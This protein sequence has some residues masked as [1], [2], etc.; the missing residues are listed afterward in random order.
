MKTRMVRRTHLA[1][2]VAGLAVSVLAV[3]VVYAATNSYVSTEAEAATRSGGAATLAD[4]SASGG[5]AVQFGTG[6]GGACPT[7]KRTITATD[8]SQVKNSGYPAGTQVYIPGSPDPW[9]GCFPSAANTGIPAGTTLT[10]YTGPCTITTPNTTIT[11]R[12]INCSLSIRAANVVIEHSK[13]TGGNIAIDSAGSGFILRDSEVDFGDNSDDEG[14]KGSN[15]TVQRANLYGGKRQIWCLNTCLLEDSY[16]HD[17]LMDPTGQTHESAA[18]VEQNTTLRHNTLWCNAVEVPPNAGCSANQTGYPDFAPIH[19]NTMERNLYMA[20]TGGTCS[21]GGSTNGKPY[22][23]HA[24]NGH[25]IRLLHNVFQRGTS[26]NDRNY[27]LTDKRRY[28]CGTYGVLRDF[29][30]TKP[31]FQATGNMWDDGQLFAND[32]TYPYGNLSIY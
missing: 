8:V 31:G 12:T 14:L 23:N 20:T 17:Q 26:P 32:S 11:A 30:N 24:Q 21:Y 16:L 22:T 3:S 25:N 13:I 10:N 1:V 6:S 15:W 4:A 7:T 29:D 5:S 18:R 28:T 19:G 27:A 2:L 9:G